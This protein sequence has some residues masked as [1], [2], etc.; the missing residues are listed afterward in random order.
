MEPM[1]I[2]DAAHQEENDLDAAA[3]GGDRRAMQT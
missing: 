3:C 1:P 2:L